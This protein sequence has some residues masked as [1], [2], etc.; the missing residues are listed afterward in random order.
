[1][2]FHDSESDVS[3]MNR[4]SF[5]RGVTVHPWTWQVMNAAQRVAQ[6]SD[7]VFDVTVAPLLMAS[8]SL[9]HR[10]YHFDAAA[11]WQDIFLRKNHEVFF[12]RGLVVDLGGI[13]KGFA[14]DRAVEALQLA[15][16]GSGIVNGGGDL[17]IFGLEG[18]TIHLRHPAEP[19]RTA[20]TVKLS[21]RA[22]ATSATYFA[23]TDRA[24]KQS[25]S[26]ID[27]RARRVVSDSLSVTVAAEDC[28]TADAL[29]KVVFARREKARP[30]LL[31][32]RADALLLERNG[33][34]C[35]MFHAPCDT[36]D[37]IRSG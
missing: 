31:R 20:G 30:L 4:A 34:P 1:M 2:S 9:P 28:M 8:R 3:R 21:Q 27:G 35:W 32:Y 29:T 6:E 18:R 22:V 13:A 16:V 36:R 10:G 5:P 7:G 19:Y 25:G 37:R 33:A 24:G 14:V 15:G 17:R 11:T 23:E 12:R 26:L